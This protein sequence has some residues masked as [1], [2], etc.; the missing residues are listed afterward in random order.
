M[1]PWGDSI[2]LAPRISHGS[3]SKWPY[4]L[5]VGHGDMGTRFQPPD[6]VNWRAW[7]MMG[8]V[9]IHS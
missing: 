4:S 6:A 2:G 9:R 7:R 8:H 5:A 3:L 1:V